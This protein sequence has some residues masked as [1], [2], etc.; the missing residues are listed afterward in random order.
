MIE[1]ENIEQSRPDT[2]PPEWGQTIIVQSSISNPVTL[3]ENIRSL[4]Q[5]V[6]GWGRVWD[7]PA[8][9]FS[10]KDCM[11]QLP[12]W[13][14][15]DLS[16]KTSFINDVLEREWLWWSSMAMSD[17]IKIDVWAEALPN[18][19][20]PLCQV[21]EAAGGIILYKDSWIDLEQVHRL[22]DR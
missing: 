19:L 10:D 16:D 8:P 9:H 22:L 2:H 3:L 4:W 13:I 14:T 7:E 17:F 15:A 5:I 11:E 12:A 20:Y 18:S 21:I 1:L 6:A